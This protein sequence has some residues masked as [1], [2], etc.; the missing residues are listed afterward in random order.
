MNKSNQ[1]KRTGKFNLCKRLNIGR[2][3]FYNKVKGM[4]IHTYL[5]TYIKAYNMSMP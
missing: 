3:R 2:F 5:L 4:H 1:C